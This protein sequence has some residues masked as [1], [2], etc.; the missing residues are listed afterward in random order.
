MYYE[1][2]DKMAARVM[3]D[4]STKVAYLQYKIVE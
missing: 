3:N 2:I 4:E 1:Y